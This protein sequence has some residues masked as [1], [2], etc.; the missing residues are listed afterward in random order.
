M[1][2]LADLWLKEGHLENVL[3]TDTQ[4]V[5]QSL[6]WQLMQRGVMSAAGGPM[7]VSQHQSCM[8]TACS[9][10]AW[11]QQELVLSFAKWPACRRCLFADRT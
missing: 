2:D 9:T 11:M 7:E 5:S 1:S 10:A 8:A 6:A 4:P 3:A